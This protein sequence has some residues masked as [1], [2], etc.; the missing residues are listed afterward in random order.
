MKID[1]LQ[2]IYDPTQNRYKI[3]ARAEI[4]VVEYI[5]RDELTSKFR[6]DTILAGAKE[7]AIAKVLITVVEAAEKIRLNM[8]QQNKGDH[9]DGAIPDGNNA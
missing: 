6:S 5:S 7:R 1:V 2:P 4:S 8:P 9:N 3:V